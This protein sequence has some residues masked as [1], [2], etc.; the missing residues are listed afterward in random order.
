MSEAKRKI[1]LITAMLVMLGGAAAWSFGWMLE[2]RE[3]ARLDAE[4]LAACRQ[5]AE[6]I[7]KLRQQPAVAASEA[8]DVQELGTRITVASQQA[9]LADQLQGVFPQ[10]VRRMGDSPYVQKSTT[11]S[12]RGVSLVQIATFL[13]H[14]TLDSGLNVRDLRIS[15]KDAGPG[16][17][18]WDAEADVAYLIYQPTQ[19]PRRQP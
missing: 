17:S 5:L 2:Q 15:S 4:D 8:M 1:V 6:S 10:P 3:L 14:L 11:L 18:L 13:H 16:G 19:S 12:L 7:A 9:G